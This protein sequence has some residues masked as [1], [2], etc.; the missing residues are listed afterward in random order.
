MRRSREE[1]NSLLRSTIMRASSVYVTCDVRSC[2]PVL[3]AVSLCPQDGIL[4]H[5]VPP[6]TLG[7]TGLVG[8][9]VI[10]VRTVVVVNHCVGRL[11]IAAEPRDVPCT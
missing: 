1:V 4:L 6:V 11:E 7:L 2:G 10:S 5:V 9:D 3:P 8:L